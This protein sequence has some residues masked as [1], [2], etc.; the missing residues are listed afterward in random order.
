VHLEA[1][2]AVPSAISHPFSPSLVSSLWR[3][4][5]VRQLVQ[6]VDAVLHQVVRTAS[7]LALEH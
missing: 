6:H 7:P 4:V 2:R 3:S 5:S 1:S